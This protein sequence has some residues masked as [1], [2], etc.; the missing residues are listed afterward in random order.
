MVQ[1]HE[2]FEEHMEKY[3][4]FQ[5]TDDIREYINNLDV[6]SITLENCLYNDLQELA[7]Y[8]FLN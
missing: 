6:L 3:N 8:I 2:D 1:R 4:Y 5:K 7:K